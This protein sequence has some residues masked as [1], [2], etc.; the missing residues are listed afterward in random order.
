MRLKNFS[1]FILGLLL[2]W[3]LHTSWD[4]WQAQ[5]WLAPE[6]LS[7]EDNQRFLA[8]RLLLEVFLPAAGFLLVTRR[9][10]LLNF[11]VTAMILG[12]V[13]WLLAYPFAWLLVESFSFLFAPG[14]EA[15]TQEYVTYT[16]VMNW[17]TE[18]AGFI[19]GVCCGLLLLARSR[20]FARERHV[21]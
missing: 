17:L 8:I 9:F 4:V 5:S 18:S 3:I 21:A 16:R 6:W 14:S 10:S 19:A 1:S 20:W 15:S 7:K 2:V 12:L 11:P 13:A